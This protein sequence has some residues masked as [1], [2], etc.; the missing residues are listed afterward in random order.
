MFNRRLIFYN[1]YSEVMTND[2]TR[3]RTYLYP[4]WFLRGMEIRG[5]KIMKDDILSDINLI[6]FSLT[7]RFR[8]VNIFYKERIL[9]CFDN[10]WARKRVLIQNLFTPSLECLT[11]RIMK[12]LCHQKYLA[13]GDMVI[14]LKYLPSSIMTRYMEARFN[15]GKK[16]QSNLKLIVFSEDPYPLRRVHVD[17]Q[18]K[19]CL[20]FQ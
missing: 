7:T 9:D 14:M 3:S 13:R 2:C 6:H 19:K 1:R 15:S 20:V 11:V 18:I 8:W 12:S 17:R 10:R 5:Y 16:I 4:F